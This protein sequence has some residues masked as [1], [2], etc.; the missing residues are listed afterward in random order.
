MLGGIDGVR[1]DLLDRLL[2]TLAVRLR[3]FSV[4][5]GVTHEFFGMAPVVSDADKAQDVAAQD[6]REAFAGK[7]QAKSS[8]SGRMA[9]PQSPCTPHASGR[10]ARMERVL[11]PKPGYPLGSQ[12]AYY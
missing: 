9:T 12:A 10:V 8:S 3:A 5:E 6:L 11:Q 4:Y 2:V 1:T 7:P